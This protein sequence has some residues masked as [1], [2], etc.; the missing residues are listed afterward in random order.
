MEATMAEASNTPEPLRLIRGLPVAY[1]HRP[2]IIAET[3]YKLRAEM[4]KAAFSTEQIW[5]AKRFFLG[6]VYAA[7]SAITAEHADAET[8]SLTAHQLELDI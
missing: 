1:P 4:Y 5:N 3:W 8:L 7:S 6:G 2:R